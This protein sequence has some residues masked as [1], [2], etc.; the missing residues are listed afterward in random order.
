ML[1]SF[2]CVCA[3]N[4]RPNMRTR[5]RP[6]YKI[7]QVHYYY[8][9][10]SAVGGA[11]DSFVK[12]FTIS[13]FLFILKC[14]GKKELGERVNKQ[15]RMA[16]LSKD[17]K[18]LFLKMLSSN[19]LA[20]MYL[21]GCGVP[22]TVELLQGRPLPLFFFF[23]VFL[24]GANEVCNNVVDVMCCLVWVLSAPLRRLC[25]GR[26]LKAVDSK[27]GACCL[28]TKLVLL[29]LFSKGA[30]KERARSCCPFFLSF[31]PSSRFY[32]RNGTVIGFTLLLLLLFV[33]GSPLFITNPPLF[34]VG[35]ISTIPPS[36]SVGNSR[37]AMADVCLGS[38]ISRAHPTV[39]V[40]V[41]L[42][43]MKLGPAVCVYMYTAYIMIRALTTRR[44]S[45]SL[46]LFK[47]PARSLPGKQIYIFT[48][49]LISGAQGGNKSTRRVD[50]VQ[51]DPNRH[52]V[53]QYRPHFVVFSPYIWPPLN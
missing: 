8:Y 48:N 26:L 41:S 14:G 38:D 42:Y 31:C 1:G 21:F 30:F 33:I 47:I 50:I 7:L 34:R 51:D 20:W 32:S 18:G 35:W 49:L 23:F 17:V 11:T 44:L 6:R 5:W 39:C 12:W 29:W 15:E 25:L 4:L 45:F 37:A 10:Y 52:V 46:L 2:Y 36:Y 24:N 3:G 27:R 13:F 16:P 40:C 19:P 28:A 22:S 43:K 9:Y 53:L